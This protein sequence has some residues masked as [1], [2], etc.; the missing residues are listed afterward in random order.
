MSVQN[1]SNSKSREHQA[2]ERTFLAWVRTGIALMGFGFV[3]VKFALFLKQISI[4]LEGEAVAPT[5]GYSAVVGVVMVAL[6]IVMT[7]LAF[8]QYRRVGKQLESD[9]YVPSSRL[10]VLLTLAILIGGILLIVYLIPN[11]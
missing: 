8:W 7:L 9:T 5:R 1:N 2:N 4:M 10:S 6:G 11:I 3:I